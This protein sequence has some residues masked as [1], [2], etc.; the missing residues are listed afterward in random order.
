MTQDEN[1]DNRKLIKPSNNV[2]QKYQQLF[3]NYEMFFT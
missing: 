3:Y 2:P 1:I